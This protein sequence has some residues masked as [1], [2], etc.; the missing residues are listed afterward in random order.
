M[1]SIYYTNTTLWV[2]G[3]DVLIALSTIWLFW[4]GKASKRSNLIVAT[5]FALAIATLH[6]L[7]GQKQIP[8]ST[9]AITFYIVIL[10]GA[11][12][13]VLLLERLAAR[14]MHNLDQV[15]LQLVQGLRVFIGGGFLMEGV[16]DVIPQ[17]FSIMDGFFHIS[18]GFL[19]LTGAIALL[20]RY[21]RA[22]LI[23]WIA[24]IVG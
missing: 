12:T 2:I 20:I 22:K 11:G 19:A 8:E 18:S 13:I 17:A 14:V 15:H 1:D 21:R 24:N 23:L 10:G 5:L 7:F 4:K 16:V 3:V 6:W 9:P